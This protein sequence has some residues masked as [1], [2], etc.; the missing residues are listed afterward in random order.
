M[1]LI[2]V[3]GIA[4]P[5]ARVIR[6]G[7][8]QIEVA[9]HGNDFRK[10]H[11]IRLCDTSGFERPLNQMEYGRAGLSRQVRQLQHPAH[12]RCSW[13]DSPLQL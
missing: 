2:D 5:A 7:V 3:V 10:R 9:P 6:W 12:S 4:R 11:M 13:I 1:I 8:Q